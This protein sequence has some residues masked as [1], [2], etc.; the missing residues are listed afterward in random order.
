MTAEVELTIRDVMA[1]V[2]KQPADK[3]T[4]DSSVANTK[5]W[6]STNHI[7]LSLALED[8]FDISLDVSEIER[9]FSFAEIL[10]VVEAKI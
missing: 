5:N 8:E 6:D 10:R 1:K 3:I 2:L 9:I 4:L 7:T